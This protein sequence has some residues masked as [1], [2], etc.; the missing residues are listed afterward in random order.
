[1]VQCAYLLV[2][3]CL[4]LVRVPLETYIFILN[5]SLPSRSEQLSGVNANEIKY[6]HSPVVIVVLGPGT[7]NLTMPCILL[8]AL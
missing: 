3:K 2:A 8:A 4:A 6:Y 7:I 5:F 1:M